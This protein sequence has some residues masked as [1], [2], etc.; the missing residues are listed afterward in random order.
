MSRRL[1]LPLTLGVLPALL[2]TLVVAIGFVLCTQS[3]LQAA[4]ALANRYGGEHLSIGSAQGRLLG[5]SLLSNVHYRGSNGLQVDI[6]RLHL[7]VH[8]SELLLRRLHVISAEIAGLHVQLPPPDDTPSAPLR[9]LPQRL[10]L[11]VVIDGFVLKDFQL[12]REHED[13][14]NLPQARLAASWIG[15]QLQIT[16]LA[17][18]LPQTGALQASGQ[19]Q[20]SGD[21][22][23]V[24]QLTIKGPGEL[25]VKGRFGIDKVASDL[26]LQWQGLRWPLVAT[27]VPPT[28]SGFGGSLHVTGPLDGFHYELR[29]NA[30]LRKV[31][32]KFDAD[33]G[34]SLDKL[35]VASLDLA[36]GQGSLYAQGQID[37]A[38]ALRADL[39]LRFTRFDPGL[40]A[41]GWEGEIY[42]I[43]RTLTTQ[44]AG[45]PQIGFQVNITPSTLRG[46]PLTLTAVGST[47]LR[48]VELQRFQLQSGKGRVDGKGRVAWAPSLSADAQLQIAHFN[49]AQFLPQWRGDLNGTIGAATAARAGRDVVSFNA[50]IADSQLR[51]HPLAL[52][53][54]GELAD[55]NLD[56]R[57]FAL[58]AGT[59]NLSANGRATPPFDLSGKFDS[60]DLTTLL[61]DLYGHAQLTF[62]LQGPLATPHLV[63]QGAAASVRYRGERLGALSWNADLDP[64]QPSHL[65]LQL[66]DA[67]LAGQMVQ[68][69]K[70]AV[71]GLEIYQHIQFD[72][73]T[74]RGDLSLSADGGYNR[75][76][77]E[78]GGNVAALRLTP[79]GLP[80][81]T[82]EKP[83]GLLLGKKR[84]S[85]EPACLSG[86][87]GRVCLRLEQNVVRQGLRL[88]W[89]LDRLALATFKPVLPPNLDLSGSADGNGSI[90]IAQGDIAA[91]SVVLNLGRS[92]IEVPQAPPLEILPSSFRLDD[93]SGRL[94]ATLD[95]QTSRG[96]V[97]AD[98]SAAPAADYAARALSGSA[99]IDVPDLGLVGTLLPALQDTAGRI[100]G[101]L[102]FGGSIGLP[103]IGGHLALSDGRARLAVAG[104]TLE[105][106]Q[107]QASGNGDGPLTLTGTMTSGGGTLD[108]HGSVDPSSSPLHADLTL[109]GENVQVMATPDARIWASPDLYLLAD[110][111]VIRLD[112]TLAVPRAEITPHELDDNG[113]TVSK[114]QVIVGAQPAEPSSPLKIYSQLK[115]TL[116]D[117]VEVKSFG[118]STRLTG[119]VTLTDEPQRETRAQGELQLVDGHYKAY[120]QDLS[121][122]NGRLIFSG[123][124]V[125][126]PA[127]D[128]YATRRPQQDITIGVRVRGT[129][130]KPQLTLQSDPAM[131]RE[132]QLSWL[133][134]GRSLDQSS[135]D[136]RSAM[137]QAALTLGL[138]GGDYLAQKL[139]AGV[140]L[141]QVS[142]GQAPVTS[143][144]VAAD[145]TAISG[146]RAAQNVGANAYTTQAAQLTLGKYLTPKLFVSYGVSLFQ[147]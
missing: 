74:E 69:A 89:T 140:G 44:R 16:Q 22:V 141:D 5:E 132:Q 135:S 68:S 58:T 95:L 105:N 48:S 50:R 146:S 57:R 62:K 124:P 8:G 43:A 37:W 125:T 36:A 14:L 85:V 127:V 121:I 59:T 11:N 30:T 144:S 83:I 119:A 112:G 77:M 54:Q 117:H 143:S 101:Q 31:P 28:L 13:L 46:Q 126:Q 15:R 3:G 92:R 129:L 80:A 142:I 65:T 106:L 66:A 6:R 86:D 136:D 91:A 73:D 107:L 72:A 20:M 138:S 2:L 78:W 79:A 98:A 137:S 39:T 25:S 23:D 82:L 35:R 63:T 67:Q 104:I 52:T 32:L 75:K 134:L 76:K 53:A 51:G 131:P 88:S 4:V 71:T 9:E 84:Q 103:R 49:P 116:G 108:L 56:L 111:G 24:Q 118:L 97:R 41:E 45:H 128:L 47:D 26:H 99:Q 93:Q 12:S 120:G 19:A 100:G 87:G 123:G 96:T 64:Q 147:P 29:G 17:A 38:P 130:D 70:L 18:E 114:D 139:G 33:G 7:R 94:H 145:A 61:P 90:E 115:L 110:A 113:V 1:R 60:P 133:V 109:S 81:W 34:G 55:G 40:F 102:D 10:P 27:R 21:H 122:Q 42:G